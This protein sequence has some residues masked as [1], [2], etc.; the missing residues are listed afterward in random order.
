MSPMQAGGVREFLLRESFRYAEF[1]DPRAQALLE[2]R[3]SGRFCGHE[4]ASFLRPAILAFL[5]GAFQ[6]LVGFVRVFLQFFRGA[7]CAVLQLFARLTRFGLQLLL[8]LFQF[9]A[10]HLVVFSGAG[11]QSHA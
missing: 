8:G 7:M 4:L 11:G 6:L 1:S 3:G 2:L 5:R 10:R 9:P